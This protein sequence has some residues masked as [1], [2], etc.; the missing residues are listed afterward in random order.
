MTERKGVPWGCGMGWPEAKDRLSKA[1]V[2]QAYQE[3]I[4][5][6]VQTQIGNHRQRYRRARL[7]AYRHRELTEA[8]WHF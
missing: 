5:N 4:D 8:D 7:E 6:A 2:K 3:L 1:E